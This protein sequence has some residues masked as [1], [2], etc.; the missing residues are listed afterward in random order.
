MRYKWE[1]HRDT[2]GRSTLSSGLRGTGSIAVPFFEKKW[3]LV[4]LTFFQEIRRLH[5]LFILEE[6]EGEGTPEKQK[7]NPLLFIQNV[8]V[9]LS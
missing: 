6:I 4:F 7:S 3:W 8:I 2:N 1:V 5:T 9:S